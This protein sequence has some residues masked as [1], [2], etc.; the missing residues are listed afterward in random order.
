MTA[1]DGLTWQEAMRRGH[2]ALRESES[3]YEGINASE[4]CPRHRDRH[5]PHR[6]GRVSAHRRS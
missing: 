3:L 5:D 2:G 4:G 6:P 1:F